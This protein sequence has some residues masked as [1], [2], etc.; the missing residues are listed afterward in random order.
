MVW[1][2][3]F[4]TAVHT[5]RYFTDYGGYHLDFSG[6]VHTYDACVVCISNDFSGSYSPVMVMVQKV[7]LAAYALHDGETV[8]T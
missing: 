4:M 6:L 2:L 7:T 8:H 3:G 1:G 5:Y